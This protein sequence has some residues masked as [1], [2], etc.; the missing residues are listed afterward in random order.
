MLLERCQ[1]EFERDQQALIEELEKMDVEDRELKIY[2]VSH[3]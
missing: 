2:Q 3:T 1:K